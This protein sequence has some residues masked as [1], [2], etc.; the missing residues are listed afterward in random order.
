VLGGYA[1]YTQHYEMLFSVFL[2]LLVSLL[3][4]LLKGTYNIHV[5]VI[6]IYSTI[7]FIFLSVFL[8]QFGGLYDRWLW[9]DSFLHFIS[10]LTFGFTGFIIIY[11]YYV[12]N[13][14]K[15]PQNL[16]LALTFFF[17]LGIGAL[18]EIIEYV[19][20]N[21]LGTNMQVN[22]LDDTMIDLII[23]ALGG[24]TAVIICSLYLS[25][26]HVPVIDSVVKAITKE[27]VEENKAPAVAVRNEEVAK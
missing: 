12:H 11:V 23:G 10:A 2:M 25:R 26:F 8:G 21:A 24:L 9:W 16:I 6:F 18:W 7:V 3:P 27:T 5:P 17:C 19:I 20:D 14:L 15:I 22:S 4:H 1:V 13:K